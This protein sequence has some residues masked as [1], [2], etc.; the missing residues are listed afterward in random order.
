MD[1]VKNLFSKKSPEAAKDSQ[2][3]KGKEK[4]AFAPAEKGNKSPLGKLEEI[5]GMKKAMECTYTYEN[6]E[7]KVYTDGTNMRAQAKIQMGEDLIDSNTIYTPEYLYTWMEG[8]STGT[9][10]SIK[11]L[12]EVD[13]TSE[14]EETPIAAP[15]YFVNM[16]YSCE[17]KAIEPSMF[18]LPEGV[19]FTELNIPEMTDLVEGVNMCGMCDSLPMASEVEACKTEFNCQ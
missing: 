18:A 16:E 4:S 3:E 12:E 11:D 13:T 9:K 5:L 17:D 10:I 1:D 14:T 8:Q 6:L 2:Q 15:D 7:G 19:E